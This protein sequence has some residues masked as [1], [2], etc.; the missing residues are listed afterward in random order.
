MTLLQIII[1]KTLHKLKKKQNILINNYNNNNYNNMNNNQN[2][3]N[4]Y[5]N[6]HNNNHNNYYNRNKQLTLINGLMIHITSFNNT[7]HNTK[8]TLRDER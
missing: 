4:N 8:N 7:S 6:N 3:N 5:Y 1:I 2:Q